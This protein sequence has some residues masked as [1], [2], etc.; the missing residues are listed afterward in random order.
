MNFLLQL[1]FPATRSHSGKLHGSSNYV[2]PEAAEIFSKRFFNSFANVKMSPL[3]WFQSLVVKQR[4]QVLAIICTVASLLEML[5][6][7]FI[8]FHWSAGEVAKA[9]LM[10]LIFLDSQLFSGS[11]QLLI[12][13]LTERPERIQTWL[14]AGN[15]NVVMK[16]TLFFLVIFFSAQPWSVLISIGLNLSIELTIIFA[17]RVIA[18]QYRDDLNERIRLRR[19]IEF[20][21][22]ELLDANEP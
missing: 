21:Q 6:R 1:S 11:I 3:S 16:A 15:N 2:Y 18:L 13:S 9:A 8:L 4:F 5:A 7:F 20:I 17:T 10:F 12:C 19:V 14:D 22:T